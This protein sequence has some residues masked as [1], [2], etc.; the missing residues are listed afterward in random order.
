MAELTDA[1]FETATRRGEES[2]RTEPHAKAV[3]YDAKSGRLIID[4][5][6]GCVFAIPTDLIQHV[7]D[8]PSEEIAKVRLL[9]SF[10]SALEWEDADI[11]FSVAGLVAGHFGSQKYMDSQWASRAGSVTSPAKAA[12]ARANGAKGGRPRKSA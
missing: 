8:M 9:G 12:A 6:N 5:T 10:G 7:R 4:L 11:H 1:E 2:L 3:R